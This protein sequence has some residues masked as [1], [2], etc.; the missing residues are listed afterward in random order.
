[1]TDSVRDFSPSKA[2][3]SSDELDRLF[4]LSVQMLCIAGT[5]GYFKR[6]NPAF[7]RTLGHSTEEMLVRP[8]LDFVH[9]D[10]RKATVEEI[11]KLEA[12][13]PT[14]HF[15]NRFR[16]K[17][18]SYRWLV[19]T[20]SPDAQNG[21]LYA[22]ALDVTERKRAE[23]FYRSVIDSA[24]DA[25]L[26]T[27]R[28]GRILLVNRLT[29]T[30]FGYG[31]EDLIDQTIELLVPERLRESHVKHREHYLG[32]PRVRP[33]GSGIEL[34]GRR[35][36]GSEFPAEISLSPLE[37]DGEALV[38]AAV[39]NITQRKRTE[40]GLRAKEAELLAAQGIQRFILPSETPSLPGFDIAGA[41]YPTELSGGDHLDFIPMADGSLGIVIGDVTGHGVAAGLIM[42]STHAFVRA[43][44]EA[45]GDIAGILAQ[46]NRALHRMTDADRF[47]TLLLAELDP[48]SRVLSYVNAGHPTGYVLDGKGDVR[49][50][51]ESVGIPL[52]IL[53]EFDY[54]K[55]PPISL[56]TGDLVLLLTDGLLEAESPS[57]EPFGAERVLSV[58][59]S[60]RGEPAARVIRSLHTAVCRFAGNDHL[61]DDLT[62][63][64]VRVLGNGSG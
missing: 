52:A 48:V 51:L 58:V 27:D 40:H 14:V 42:A 60:C 31:R 32:S 35:R 41:T 11:R 13:E 29:E 3:R 33:M 20:S 23:Q 16:C 59:R 64:V 7:E 26:I 4:S 43:F 21:L 5:D 25:V 9:P 45:D 56:Q 18:G 19:W 47:V 28:K 54:P 30:L 61:P 12:G 50:T 57:G 49:C 55:R 46:A 34:S 37:V 24:P 1:M 22:T 6:L 38:F 36:D 39:R 8:L 44:G 53:P 17:D 15:E 2:V 10:D 62:A 63:I